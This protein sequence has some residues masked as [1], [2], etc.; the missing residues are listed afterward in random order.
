M[1]RM[2]NGQLMIKCAKTGTCNVTVSAIAGGST[3]GSDTGAGGMR[4]T[5]KFAV[6]VRD[7]CASNGG[8]L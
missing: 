5:K 4:I 3:V 8:W 6:V 2:Y 7:H 1:L